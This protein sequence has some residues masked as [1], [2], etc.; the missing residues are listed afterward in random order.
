MSLA[1]MSSR[2]GKGGNQARRWEEALIEE[3]G[4]VDGEYSVQWNSKPGDG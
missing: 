1:G 2:E 4:D 3:K